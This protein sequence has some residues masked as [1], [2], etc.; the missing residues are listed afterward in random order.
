MSALPDRELS[1][2]TGEILL[3]AEDVAV[4][5]GGVR[6]VDGVSLEVRRGEIVGLIGPNGSGKTTL[7]QTLS[8]FLRS[9][10]GAIRFRG[11]RIDRLAPE[12]ICRRGLARTFQIVEIFPS[13]TVRETLIAAMLLRMPMGA[14]RKAAAETAALVGLE[15]KLDFTCGQLTLPDQK[16]LEIG[17]AVATAPQMI[18]LDEVMAGLRPSETEALTELILGLR[19]RGVTFL[20]VEHIMDI[21]TRLSDRLIV[22]GAG[23]K[24]AEGAPKDV[25]RDPRVIDIY[26]GEEVGLA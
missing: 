25:M 18:L 10:G 16:A 13:L 6:A 5:F 8:G 2:A 11:E 17:K 4:H 21:V 24:V 1:R 20:F 19:A 23:K 14:A 22:L 12:E 26:L 9:S 3:A 7:F 15:D